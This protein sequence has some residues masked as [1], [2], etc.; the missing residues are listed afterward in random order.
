MNRKVLLRFVGGLL[1]VAVLI[2]ILYRVGVGNENAIKAA[3]EIEEMALRTAQNE[4]VSVAWND[5]R[6]IPKNNLLSILFMGVDKTSEA[7]NTMSGYR[8]RGQADFLFLV[9][10]D[11]DA[12]T[13]ERLMIDRDSM[14][15]I[16]T[17]GIFGDVSGTRIERISL[18]HSFGDGKEQSCW[19]TVDA[20][21]RLLGDIKIDAFVAMDLDAVTKLNDAVGGVMLM[22]EEDLTQVDPAMVPG[23]IVRLQGDQAERLV[24]SRMNVGDG[25]N[26]SRMNRQRAFLDA[27]ADQITEKTSEDLNFIGFLFDQLQEDLVTNLSRG[28]MINEMNWAK[29]YRTGPIGRIQGE[30]MV[31][32][33][34]FTA[35]Y[36]D[37]EMIEQWVMNTFYDR[38]D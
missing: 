35:F 4:T 17:L 21:S 24:R 13:V 31:D 26:A 23:A 22:I 33:E 36:P 7:L 29:G 14:T 28:R 3:I 8:N 25:T 20:A 32:N 30:H 15:E 1:V 37:N 38:V 12:K 18:S 9:I 27:L 10:I 11:R 2:G 16:T 19:F 34:G 6:Y 5:Q